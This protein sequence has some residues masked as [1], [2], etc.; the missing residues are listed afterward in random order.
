[1]REM[2]KVVQVIGEKET[3]RMEGRW[4]DGVREKS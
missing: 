1:M 3:I 2:K 4:R